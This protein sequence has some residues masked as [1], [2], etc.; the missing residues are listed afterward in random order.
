MDD[1]WIIQSS[2]MEYRANIHGVAM[3]S[4]RIFREHCHEVLISV[5]SVWVTL[6]TLRDHVH[7]KSLRAHFFYF[8]LGPFCT[9]SELLWPYFGV[10][11]RSFWWIFGVASG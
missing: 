6:M 2:S 3:D 8:I 11:F 7:F 1:Q 4:P 10:M 5:L 9:Y